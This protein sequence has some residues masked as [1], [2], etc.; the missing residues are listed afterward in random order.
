MLSVPAVFIEPPDREYEPVPLAMK[1]EL[2]TIV[3]KRKGRD[4][5]P[6]Q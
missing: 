4:S 1:D 5:F 2:S 3:G 6:N